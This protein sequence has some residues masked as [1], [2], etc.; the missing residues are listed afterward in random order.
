MRIGFYVML[1]LV[2]FG[3]EERGKESESVRDD[4]VGCCKDT[5]IT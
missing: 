5:M 3:L 4:Q 1:S 2:S